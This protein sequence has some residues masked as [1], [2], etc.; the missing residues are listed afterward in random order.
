MFYSLGIYAYGGIVR[1]ASLWN[2]K[3]RKWILGRKNF[4]SKLP[5]IPKNKE[6]VWFHCASMGEYDQGLPVMESFL[7]NF[8]NTYLL[9]T[10]FSPSG[11][12]AI[13]DKSIADHTCYLP[14][15]TKRNAKRFVDHFNPKKVFFVK[16]EFW[17]NYIDSCYRSDCKLFGLSAVFREDQRFFKWYGGRFTSMIDKFEHFFLQNNKSARTLS[18]NDYNNFTV[19]GDTRFDRVLI[20]AKHNEH[21]PILEKW[22][23]RKR[24]VLVI[25][26]SWPKDEEILYPLIND[27]ESSTAVIL[28]PHEVNKEH[29]DGI[30]DKLNVPFQKY[31]DLLKGEVV[32]STTEV[33]ILDCIGVLANAYKY[34][35]L[36]YV[37]GAFGKGLH[38]ILEPASFGLPVVFGPN[39]KKFPEAQEFIDA[40]I[41]KSI[42]DEDSCS[43]A[44][45]VF[46]Q[47]SNCDKKVLDIMEEKSGATSKV[48][49]YF[50]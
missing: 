23:K 26:S 41:G 27:T 10:F 40:K 21:N 13:K 28:A 16:Y 15:D 2:A 29:I 7:D 50:Q 4:W 22:T 36:A 49:S 19:T 3:A 44:L 9:V 37:G 1:L 33:I 11:Y 34:G 35:T 20:R 45:N 31:T 17:L 25:G 5:T 48:I 30:I 32:E 42:N 43:L 18:I 47:D 8:P 46:A 14:L 38:N 6:V 39:H 12:E 24:N